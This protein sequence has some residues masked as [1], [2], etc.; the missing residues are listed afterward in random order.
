MIKFNY[1]LARKFHTD[2][3]GNMTLVNTVIVMWIVL[4][5]AFIFNADRITQSRTV[6]QSAADFA[7]TSVGDLGADSM[8]D[9]VSLNH[10]IGELTS[11]VIIH[12]SW[13]GPGLDANE[14]ANTFTYDAA[15]LAAKTAYLAAASAAPYPAVTIAYEDVKEKVVASEESTEF[16]TKTRLKELLTWTYLTKAVACGMIA[17][18]FPPVVAAGVALHT[19]ADAFELK[20]KQEYLT[21]NL[22]HEA[23]VA[24]ITVKQNIRDIAL[25]QL[26]RQTEQ[27]VKQFPDMAKRYAEE[28]VA[29]FGDEMKVGIVGSDG[30]PQLPVEIDPYAE[31]TVLPNLEQLPADG[32]LP[33]LDIEES[34]ITRDQINKVTQ[35]A[36]TTFPW[37]VYDR[38]PLL[39][40]MKL[41]MTLAQTHKHYRHYTEKYSKDITSQLQLEEDMGLYV[42]KQHTMNKGYQL[43]TEDADLADKLFSFVVVV[44]KES[45][46]VVGQSVVFSQHNLN[47][48]FSTSQV[49]LYNGNLQKRNKAHIDLTVKRIRP[50][51]QP[52]VGY[53]TLGWVEKQNELIAKTDEG[54]AS[55]PRQPKYELNWQ[56]KLEPMS[57]IMNSA[58]EKHADQLP[59]EAQH[60]AKHYFKERPVDL[61]VQ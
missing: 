28:S 47:G 56:S 59:Q 9:L 1:N 29:S 39:K 18:K 57:N 37:V 25:P 19:T 23:M 2:E 7:A 38:E 24:L 48:V 43:W 58:V 26:K 55:V 12:E 4:I 49:T 32:S 14:E 45:P 33:F 44:H 60:A 5:I 15:L 3:S 13:G 27:I 10:T 34:G 16:E 17:S 51:L 36:R 11:K 52:V 61:L 8:K 54:G 46:A 30:K 53:D 50:N 35:L 20:I 21:A 22:M 6:T 31:A 40:G 42:I 41:L